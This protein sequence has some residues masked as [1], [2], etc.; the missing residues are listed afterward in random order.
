L[1]YRN[2]SVNTSTPTTT[3]PTSQRKINVSTTFTQAS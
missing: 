2:V 1:F 3:L